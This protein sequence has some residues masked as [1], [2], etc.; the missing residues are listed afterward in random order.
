MHFR[1]SGNYGDLF[2]YFSF[3]LNIIS[4]LDLTVGEIVLVAFILRVMCYI[5]F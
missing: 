1:A 4:K 2:M 3:A 5:I